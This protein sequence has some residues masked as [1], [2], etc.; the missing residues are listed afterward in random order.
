[1]SLHKQ[2]TVPKRKLI[3]R[4]WKCQ[5]CGK[6][7]QCT[8]HRFEKKEKDFCNVYCTRPF[9]DFMKRI[10][11]QLEESSLA[12]FDEELDNKRNEILLE[13][14]M[15][16][17][18]KQLNDIFMGYSKVVRSKIHKDPKLKRRLEAKRTWTFKRNQMYQ[19]E[20]FHTRT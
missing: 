7:L 17:P 8:T 4:C 10:T 2:T 13:V 3:S 5:W 18:G 15:R 6:V 11:Q 1:M 16:V 9:Y 19:E 14:V 20:S 12:I